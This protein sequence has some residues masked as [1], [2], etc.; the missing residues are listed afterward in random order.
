MK[1][2]DPERIAR[3]IEQQ[4]VLGHW[5][6]MRAADDAAIVRAL[7][8]ELAEA[9][10]E[11]MRT[12]ALLGRTVKERDALR[13]ALEREKARP[14]NDIEHAEAMRH[15]AGIMD[16]EAERDALRAALEEAIESAE[17][18]LVAIGHGP[19][20]GP[21]ALAMQHLREQIAR[22]TAALRG[23]ERTADQPTAA[24]GSL[25]SGAAGVPPQPKIEEF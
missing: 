5:P 23:T 25:T 18:D 10:R 11:D 1:A 2:S 9:K 3:A 4:P 20:G 22:W 14:C 12:T 24:P 7:A 15:L 8:A 6:H 13:A 21:R 19:D 17:V 16:V